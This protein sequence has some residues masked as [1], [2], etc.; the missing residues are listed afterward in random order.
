MTGLSSVNIINGAISAKYV[1]G[2]GDY[3]SNFTAWEC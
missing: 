2:F 1:G 3:E